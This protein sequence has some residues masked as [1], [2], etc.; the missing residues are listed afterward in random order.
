MRLAHF[1]RKKIEKRFTRAK[2][3]S[4]GE[5][6]VDPEAY[7]IEEDVDEENDNCQEVNQNE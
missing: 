5:L 6:T 7:Y 3:L 1:L 2:A 4:T